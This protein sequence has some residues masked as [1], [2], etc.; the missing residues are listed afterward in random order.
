MTEAEQHLCG[1]MDIEGFNFLIAHETFSSKECSSDKSS[2]PA[3]DF[4]KPS[5]RESCGN[6]IMKEL[7]EKYGPLEQ[8][9]AEGV[10]S[11]KKC[12]Q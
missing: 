5:F 2:E 3:M 1:F 6:D 8:V 12:S 11:G 4:L 7:T 9:F 10:F